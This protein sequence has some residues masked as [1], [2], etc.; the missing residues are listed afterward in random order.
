MIN[1]IEELNAKWG[2]AAHTAR[3]G[4]EWR[5]VALSIASP[6]RLLAAVREP[7]ERIALLVEGPMSTAP[8]VKLRFET[9][10]L[11]LTEQRRPSENVFRLAVTLERNEF[12]DVFDALCADLVLV[13][14]VA[15]TAI[16][17][18]AALT[19]RLEA[20][21]A[22]LRVRKGALSREEQ[23]G[24]LGEIAV[25]RIFAE[26]AG[27]SAAVEAWKGPVDG[28]HDF[29]WEGAAVEVKSVLGIGTHLHI[30]HI[31]QLEVSGLS[32]LTIGRVRFREG[33]DGKSLPSHVEAIRRETADAS[34]A[35]VSE[36]EDKLLRAGYLD[37]DAPLYS[38]IHF[39]QEALYCYAV[40]E[41][42]PRLVRA[43]IPSAIVDGS[44]TLDE[45]AISSFRKDGGYLLQILSMNAGVTHG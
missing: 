44:Y 17:A 25:L 3:S 24:L 20:W 36:L 43:A 7:D 10:G 28:V 2:E 29:V 12:K 35:T 41:K 31:D 39:V 4:H 11:S 8:S 45:K 5:G 40:E 21:Q 6:V 18:F 30:S 19:K 27:H 33:H 38:S 26:V 32:S 42:F 15:P 13:V 22:C 34:S 1:V 37:V 9:Q 16:S 23:T 14:S